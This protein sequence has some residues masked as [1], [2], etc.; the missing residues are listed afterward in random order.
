MLINLFRWCMP[1]L[2]I[3]AG[4]VVC[5]M[6]AEPQAADEPIAP[7]HDEPWRVAPLYDMPRVAT[8]EQLA[9]VLDRMKLARDPANT[10]KI[11]HSLRLWGPH[12]RF[13]DAKYLDG[14]EMRDYFLDDAV[15]RQ[16][17]GEGTPPLF[18]ISDG[19]VHTREW[20]PDD[21]HRSTGSVHIDDLL[22]TLAEIGV[23][24][25]TP[26]K[27]R[28]GE[29]TVRSL[30][31]VAMRRFHR[32]QA[33]YEWSIIS[34]GR[35]FYPAPKWTNQYG[36][37]LDADQLLD[38]LTEQPLRRGVCAGTHRLEAMIVLHQANGHV[39]EMSRRSRHKLLS[40]L[41][42]VRNLLIASQHP[43]G[44]WT[45]DWHLGS[46]A[47]NRPTSDLASR[48]LATGHH[49]EW[50]A[51]APPEIQPPRETIVRAS[52]WLIRA[53]LEVD[54]AKLSLDYGPFSHAA[55]ALCLWRNKDPYEAWKAGQ[56]SKPDREIT[57]TKE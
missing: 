26:L 7:E 14:D 33:E 28:D 32:R 34:Y 51:L 55:R 41:A 44:Y 38:E 11:V 49:L 48:I 10:N 1:L 50:L 29:T 18:S 27:T 31:D 43:E 30:A 53:M 36:E 54:E 45:R 37:T 35:Y 47:L 52:Q 21:T 19:K 9:A 5:R 23:P 46:E 20:Q 12:A 56:G 15:F 2:V 40:H 13:G 24:L 22:A 57:V 8:D 39:D 25:S 3:T 17:A 4:L 6:T 16:I 42:N